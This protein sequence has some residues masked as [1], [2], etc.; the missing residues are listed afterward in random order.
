LIRHF[1]RHYCHFAAPAD[2]AILII[3]IDDISCHYYYLIIDIF[4]LLPDKDTPHIDTPL[5]AP[6][7]AYAI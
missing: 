5:F 7:H 4:R 6:P 3:I 1:S 2:I